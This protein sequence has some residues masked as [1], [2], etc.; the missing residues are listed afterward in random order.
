MENNFLIFHVISF[1][2]YKIFL[3]YN[4]KVKEDG[5]YFLLVW[6]EGRYKRI[7]RMMITSVFTDF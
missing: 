5:F 2:I 3:L 6:F 4:V 1:I 7:K